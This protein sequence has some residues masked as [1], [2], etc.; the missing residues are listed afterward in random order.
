MAFDQARDLR[1][2]AQDSKRFKQHV[3]KWSRGSR[4]SAGCKYNRSDDTIITGSQ[5]QRE[6]L[7]PEGLNH[8]SNRLANQNI[9][10]PRDKDRYHLRSSYSRVKIDTLQELH[11]PS[12]I[13]R[14]LY[15]LLP[16]P[17]SRRSS[18]VSDNVLYSFDRVDSPGRPLTLDAF[19]KTNP[20]ETE[21]FVEKEYEILDQNGDALKGRKARQNLRRRNHASA[22]QEPDIIEDDGFELV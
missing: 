22:A 13:S 6:K 12:N 2:F 10:K 15:D 17:Q 20:K 5:S 4:P 14:S 1:S 21:K 9:V 16:S 3:E 8:H 19:V 18:I 7:R 11:D